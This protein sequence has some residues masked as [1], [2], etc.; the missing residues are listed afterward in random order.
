MS[1]NISLIVFRKISINLGSCFVAITSNVWSGPYASLYCLMI[2]GSSVKGLTVS[3][4]ASRTAW[5]MIQFPSPPTPYNLDSLSYLHHHSNTSTSPPSSYKETFEILTFTKKNPI[6][7]KNSWAVDVGGSE[8]DCL[9][10]F[11]DIRIRHLRFS[12]VVIFNLTLSK[13]LLPK[14]VAKN[15]FSVMFQRMSPV[16]K[17]IREIG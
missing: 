16:R 1:I 14:S 11:N 2:R 12:K 10:R 15:S 3:T 5:S 4:E 9:Q 6:S 7:V 13:A 17:R 8:S